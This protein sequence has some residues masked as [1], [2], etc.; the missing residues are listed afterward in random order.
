MVK[1]CPH[2]AAILSLHDSGEP[3]SKIAGRFNIPRTTVHRIV[4]RGLVNDKPRS[5]RPVS[6]TT[7]RLRKMIKERLRREPCRSMRKMAA[8]LGVSSTS[9]RRV[10]REQLNLYPYR[11]RKLHSISDKTKYERKT[12]CRALLKR[13]THLVTLFTDEKLF[14]VEEKFNPQN[15]RILATSSHEADGKGRVVFR[16]HFASSVMVWAG[17]CA[18]GRTPLI[19]VGK[20]AKINQDIYIN[21]ILEKVLPWAKDHFKDTVWTLQQDGAP[22][23]KGRRTQDW[24]R[25]NVPDFIAASD[26]PANSPDCNPMDY[27]VWSILEREACASKHATIA[28]LKESLK[29]AWDRIPQEALRAAIDAYPKRLRAI[30]RKGGGHIE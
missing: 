19:F 13:G 7:P 27:C 14:S 6:V 1:P 23:H 10:I 12:K 26:W 18:T 17:I 20:G 15:T 25:E 29:K 11:L 2:R 24:C 22:A 16:S 4:K 21:D 3:I 28:A 30:I 8:E 9:M 5:G